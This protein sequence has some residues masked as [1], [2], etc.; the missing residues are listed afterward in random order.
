MRISLRKPKRLW[1][2]LSHWGR[3]YSVVYAPPGDSGGVKSL[4]S[5]CG[6]LNELG[7][8]TIA[9]FDGPG[10]VSWFAHN[11]R[12]YDKTYQPDV[13]IYPEVHQPRLDARKIHV[14]FALGKYAPVQ[15]H[16]DLVVCKSLDILD[17][18]KGQEP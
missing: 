5:V 11:C 6:W 1:N 12:L 2:A 17:W 15:S 4:Y 3:V 18:V 9:P 10:L 13:V 16:A 14:C 8:S 7:R